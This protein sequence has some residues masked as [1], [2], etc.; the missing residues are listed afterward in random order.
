MLSGTHVWSSSGLRHGL[1]LRGDHYR[2][3]LDLWCHHRHL[4]W[5]EERE[6]AE[7]RDP[8]EYLFYLWYNLIAVK[9][10]GSFIRLIER[11]WWTVQVWTVRSLTT[12]LSAM[13][14]TSTTSTI[15]GIIFT[16]LFWFVSKT[17]QNSPDPKAMSA[18]W[19]K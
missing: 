6:T 1:L 3:Q 8:E 13:R 4:C 17:R 14:I 15:C 5:L 12:K 11:I 10:V 19:L 16:S 2:P 18:L 7:R 9:S